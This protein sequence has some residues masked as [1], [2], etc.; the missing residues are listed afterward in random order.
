LICSFIGIAPHVIDTLIVTNQAGRLYWTSGQE[1]EMFT[2]LKGTSR[3]VLLH[4]GMHHN[5]DMYTIF[6]EDVIK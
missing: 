6:R 4:M 3:G 1:L 5:L 2:M